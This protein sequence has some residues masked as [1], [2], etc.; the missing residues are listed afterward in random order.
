MLSTSKGDTISAPITL[1][2][3]LDVTNYS[4]SNTLVFSGS[5]TFNSNTLTMHGV[6]GSVISLPGNNTLTGTGTLVI[7]TAGTVSFGAGSGGPFGNA[8][9]T[10]GVTLNSGTLSLNGGNSGSGNP[11]IIGKGV[12]TINGGTIKAGGN[13]ANSGGVT[14]ISGQVWNADWAFI[15]G[16]KS[17]G[18]GAP[19]SLGTAVGTA[20]AVDVSTGGGYLL[21]PGAISNGLT[22]TGL[23]KTGPGTLILGGTNVYTGTTT[24][25]AGMLQFNKQAALYNNTPANWTAANIIV[26][27]SATLALN[28]G[29]AGEFTSGNLDT[30]LAL[31]TASGGFTNGAI[32]G[33]DTTNAAGG[34]FTYSGAI[35]NPNGGANVLALNKLGTGTLTL[36]A[37]NSYTGTTTVSAGTLQLSG[38]GTLGSSPV[39]VL[40][41]ATLDINNLN[42]TLGSTLAVSGTVAIGASGTLNLGGD[43]SG[44]ST[45]AAIT[46]G[47]LNLVT[48]RTFTAD[49]GNTLTVGATIADGNGI[50]DV[51]KAGA[52]TLVYTPNLTLSGNNTAK[53]NAGTETLS[54]ALSG[55]G[56]LIMAGAGTLA[57]TNSNSYNGATVANNGTVT[58]GGALGSAANSD[59]TANGVNYTGVSTIKFDNSTAG[60]TGTTRAKSVKLAGGSLTVS[61]NNTAN[62]ND[63]VTGAITIDGANNNG[64]GVNLIALTSGATK[65]TTLTADSLVRANG[66]V[67]QFVTSNSLG[68]AAGNNV[69][70]VIVNTV[71]TGVDFVGGGTTAGTSTLKI[72]PWAVYGTV[73][74]TSL[75]DFVTYGPNGFRPLNSASGEYATFADGTTTQNNVRITATGTTAASGVTTVNSLILSG[76]GTNAAVILGAVAGT[77][78]VNVASGAVLLMG[79]DHLPTINTNLNFGT[80]QGVITVQKGKNSYMNGAISG[81][82]GLVITQQSFGAEGSGGTSLTLGG[83]SGSSNYTGDTY[84]QARMDLGS[85]TFLPGN[86]G[87]TG[88]LYVNGLLNLNTTATIN[89]LNGNGLISRISSGSGALVIGANGANGNFSG[90][91]SLVGNSTNAVMSVNKIGS[92]TQIFSGANVYTG[93]TLV[94]NGVLK[95]GNANA[96]SSGVITV[97]G[98][99]LD[100]RD[101]NV[102]N[103]IV[104]TGTSAA[105]LLP[106]STGAQASTFAAGSNFRGWQRQSGM[107]NNTQAQLLGGTNGAAAATVTT[108]WSASPNPTKII[109]D[110]LNF[111]GTGTSTFALQLSYAATGKGAA[112]ENSF[113]SLG[114]LNGSSQWVNAIDGNTGGTPAKYLGAYDPSYTLGS[115]GVDSTNHTV[116]AVV[117]HNSEFA[118]VVPEPAALA[119]FALGGLALLRRRRAAV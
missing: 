1:S 61:G 60:V 100:L 57:L 93:S 10:G 118:V 83:V 21:L 43:V 97:T 39:N 35:A 11:N 40:S 105:V 84:I 119:L 114:W 115:W 74:M 111:K 116:W 63:V 33:L 80:A 86:A 54:G 56:N 72:I 82:G 78:T 6:S 90:A 17:M 76:T 36:S 29:G 2:S 9:F 44:N 19:I 22:A 59:L 3:A 7:D 102:S 5:T 88:D 106:T 67:V 32:A 91:F 55:S 65:T 50:F 113:A 95:A 77:G 38:A 37:A 66:G 23:T 51:T 68:A 34:V 92:G 62:S 109:S 30:L 53:V 94:S 101:F 45:T 49:T 26:S 104:I 117:N 89:G 47:S 64:S 70:N 112:W 69:Q 48:P 107:G 46:G 13:I 79:V 31:G 85:S 81:S 98:G 16:G 18:L 52:G 8:S 15:T 12:L 14:G 73:G 87:R 99:T 28:V 42:K 71:P 24:V 27:S 103:T 96:F 108:S 20:R 75:S 4:A 41:G 25:T 58:L 110:V